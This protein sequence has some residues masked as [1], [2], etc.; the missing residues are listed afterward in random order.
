MKRRYRS[1]TAR[2]PAAPRDRGPRTRQ[3]P[4]GDD[5]FNWRAGETVVGI[6]RKPNLA[7]DTMARCKVLYSRSAPE[8]DDR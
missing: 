1:T 4:I 7:S 2:A 8:G 6:R 5:V 3:L